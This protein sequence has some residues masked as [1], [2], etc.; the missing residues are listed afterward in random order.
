MTGNIWLLF[1]KGLILEGKIFFSNAFL[2][3]KDGTDR[4]TLQEG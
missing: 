4:L 1:F 3:L 2:S